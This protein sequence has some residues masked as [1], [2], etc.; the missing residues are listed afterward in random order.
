MGLTDLLHKGLAVS[1]KPTVTSDA[2]CN[3]LTA[4]ILNFRMDHLRL[5]PYHDIL[6]LY[7]LAI[8]NVLSISLP[9]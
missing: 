4:I 6:S 3:F 8:G 9:K 5:I 7:S 1:S 2:L